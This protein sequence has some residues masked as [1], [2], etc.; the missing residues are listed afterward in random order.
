MS[1]YGLYETVD[2]RDCPYENQDTLTAADSDRI[3]LFIL[4]VLSAAFDLLHCL[5]HSFNITGAALL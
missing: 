1:N 2:Y 3:I 4:M 5:C